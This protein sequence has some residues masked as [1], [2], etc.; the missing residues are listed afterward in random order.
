MIVHDLENEDT[1]EQKEEKQGEIQETNALQM[2]PVTH[3]KHLT[4]SDFLI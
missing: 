1:A 4:F 3:S 2:E